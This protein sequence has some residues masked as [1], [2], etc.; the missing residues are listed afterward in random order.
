MTI[1]GYASG[2]IRIFNILSNTKMVEVC[3]HS[4]CINAICLHPLKEVVRYI[5]TCTLLTRIAI[6]CDSG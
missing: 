6:V 4:Q 2:H 1:G 3:A 5:C